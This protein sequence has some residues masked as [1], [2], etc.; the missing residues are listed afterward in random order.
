MSTV[1]LFVVGQSNVF[2]TDTRTGP[3]N[4]LQQ[5]DV[6][7]W[8]LMQIGVGTDLR[9]RAVP[10]SPLD[11][12][13][14]SLD[15]SASRQW[16]G[17]PAFAVRRLVDVHGHS[18]RLFFHGVGASRFFD[19]WPTAGAW[20]LTSICQSH[21]A[22]AL[23]S[24][25][26]PGAPSRRVIVTIHG[27]SDGQNI[28]AKAAYETSLGTVVSALRTTLGDA[29]THVI[30]VQLSTLAAIT[31]VTDIRTAQAAYVTAQG[32]NATLIDPSSCA[33]SGDSIHYSQAGASALGD[34]IA[35]AVDALL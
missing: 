10:W 6:P 14:L 30:V 28:T 35:D 31:Y 3:A 26:Y 7:A 5:P 8:T 2:Q 24:T 25:K 19:H 9:L 32:A 20:S 18:P 27:E 15:Y 1:D 33:L 17:A 22:A 13:Y 34:L 11:C 29:N 16:C 23:A 12:R 4:V 21:I